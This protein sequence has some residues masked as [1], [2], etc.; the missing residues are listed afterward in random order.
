MDLCL[1]KEVF[2]L[3]LLK[4]FLRLEKVPQQQQL[5]LSAGSMVVN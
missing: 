4:V 3:K 1:S 2:F 5:V